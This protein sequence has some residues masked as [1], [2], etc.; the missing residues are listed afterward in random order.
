MEVANDGRSIV[1]ICTGLHGISHAL[2]RGIS[3]KCNV[4]TRRVAV[5]AAPRLSVRGSLIKH[6]DAKPING[7]LI[8]V[9]SHIAIEGILVGGHTS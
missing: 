8:V 7:V 2:L 3:G 4:G 9:E 5:S 6:R 1:K